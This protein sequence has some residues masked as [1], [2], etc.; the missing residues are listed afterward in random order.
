MFLFPLLFIVF[1]VLPFLNL[2]VWLPSPLS[3]EDDVAFSVH[4]VWYFGKTVVPA[5]WT[6]FDLVLGHIDVL[7]TKVTFPN[8]PSDGRDD[9][10]IKRDQLNSHVSGYVL[11]RKISTDQG[12][13][14][15]FRR[16]LLLLHLLSLNL[17]ISSLLFFS[18]QVR[19]VDLGHFLCIINRRNPSLLLIDIAVDL[20]L[21]FLLVWGYCDPAFFVIQG[22]LCLWILFVRL[23]IVFFVDCL[24]FLLND[25]LD[26]R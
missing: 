2:I 20:L 21:L 13:R 12:D 8:E 24:L 14:E 4:A 1:L 7:P 6:E 23:L 15:L 25:C 19:S 5:S 18:L 10:A 17:G 3:V 9:S 22:L 16:S 11:D 26:D